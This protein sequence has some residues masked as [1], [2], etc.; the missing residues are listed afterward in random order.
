[1]PKLPSPEQL[2]EAFLTKYERPGTV[3]G[4]RYILSKLSKWATDTHAGHIA[5]LTAP[6]F[7]LY[8]DFLLKSGNSPNTR[9][10]QQGIIKRFYD[11]LVTSGTLR[12]SPIPAKWVPRPVQIADAPALTLEQV[13]AMFAASERSLHPLDTGLA[14]ALGGF[15][16]VKFKNIL[17]LTADDVRSRDGHATIAVRRNDGTVHH[18]PVTAPS[19]EHLRKVMAA[20]PTGRLCAPDLSVHSGGEQIRRA[21]ATVAKKAG[22]TGPVNSRVLETSYRK[23]ILEEGIPFE[24]LLGRLGMS[25]RTTGDP[26]R[27]LLPKHGPETTGDNALAQAVH[28]SDALDLLT[29]AESLCGQSGVTPIAPIVIAGAALEMV[30][31]RMCDEKNLTPAA[32]QP[33][34]SAYS[35][36]LRQHSF[37]SKHANAVNQTNAKLRNDAAHGVNSPDVTIPQAR[38]M[39]N[40]ITLFLAGQSDP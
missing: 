28:E 30:L 19:T 21:L 32:K 9:V 27:A 38:Q 26:K 35:E 29:Q 1:M 2:I 16:G 37:I 15:D 33:G 24:V 6:H 10:A 40:S 3:A 12:V 23:R 14:I 20:R 13:E 34:I 7:H 8:A 18:R 17:E 22:V 5:N 25:P 11:Y 39:I 31:R 36:V 4:H